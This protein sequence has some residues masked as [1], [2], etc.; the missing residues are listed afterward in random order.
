MD[1]AEV[2]VTWKGGL[3]ALVVGGIVALALI[4]TG[5]RFA[6]PE[7]RDFYN[8]RFVRLVA[9]PGYGVFKTGV[10][11]FDGH[12]AQNAGDFRHHLRIN[13]FGLRNDEPV[14]AADG[15]IW[16]VGDSM[17]FGWGVERKETYTAAI[18]ENLGTPT[19]NVA[20]PG[21]NICGYQGLVARM[22]SNLRPKAVIAGLILEND[23][24]DYDCKKAAKETTEL[25]GLG[26]EA[27]SL[28]IVK[29]WLT[30]HSAFYN[31]T[32]VTLKRTNLVKDVLV[33]LGVVEEAH[34][35]R[36]TFSW[37]VITPRIEASVNEL[38]VLR[39]MF[40]SDVPFAVLVAPTRF[41]VMDNDPW[42]VEFR[43]RTVAA[44]KN[45]GMDVIDPVAGFR[46]HDFGATHFLHD[47][48]W[49]PLGHRIAADAASRWLENRLTP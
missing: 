6:M 14:E 42:F 22:P 3:I 47:G 45:R 33:G 17:A 49:T 9:E 38:A 25:K 34:A 12:F 36:K 46:E 48:H 29:R 37:D 43:T 28:E 8:A 13:A 26:D 24:S 31:F 32:A 20:G 41:E 11:G 39:D 35:Y 1:D 27:F 21:N 2:K 7:W 18:A 40:P 44:L 15:R 5:L 4:E 10:P 23:V 30:G 19:Y 16:V